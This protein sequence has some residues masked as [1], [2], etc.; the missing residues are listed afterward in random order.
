MPDTVD[1]NDLSSRVLPF[2]S[3]SDGSEASMTGP[4]PPLPHYL[5]A[6]GRA[7]AR[8]AVEGNVVSKTHDQVKI[9]PV[10]A[11]C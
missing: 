9:P 5:N 6:E 1:R 7:L 10:F 2:M 11:P 4:P 3:L 8:F